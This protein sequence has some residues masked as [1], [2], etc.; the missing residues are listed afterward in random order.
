MGDHVDPQLGNYRLLHLIGKGSFAH[1]YLGEHTHLHT[2]VA[3]K[4]LQFKLDENSTSD[5]LDK[6]STIAHLVHP[7]IL[8]VL[9]FGVQDTIPFLVMDYVPRGTLGQ[10]F[11]RGKPLPP[12]PLAPYMKQAAAAL[13]HGHDRNLL[14]RSVKPENMLL[15]PNDEIL[16]ADFG[17]T[18]IT[19]NVVPRFPAE[20]T[21]NAAY[22]APEQLQGRPCPASD[23]YALAVVAYEWLTGSRP[24]HGSLLEIARQQINRTAPVLRERV[25]HIPANIEAVVMKALN[26]DPQQRYPNVKDFSLALED[27]CLSS[28]QYAFSS[29]NP[30][31][32]QPPFP[33][34]NASRPLSLNGLTPTNAS[35]PL[36]LNGLPPT[37]AS[38]P[39]SLNGLTPIRSSGVHAIND[40]PPLK[41]TPV[42]PSSMAGIS[43]ANKTSQHN[44]NNS[45]KTGKQKEK[46]VSVRQRPTSA[47][48]P[49]TSRKRPLKL[50]SLIIISTVILIIF[51]KANGIS[52]LANIWQSATN[53]SMQNSGQNKQLNPIPASTKMPT[54]VQEK[55][56]Y[57][58][59]GTLVLNN[60]LTD[61]NGSWQQGTMIAN[62]GTCALTNSTGY[63]VTAP[64]I[65]P[66]ECIEQQHTYTNFTYEVTM[67]FAAIKQLYSGGGITFRS[68]SDDRQYYYFELFRNGLY[69]LQI[70]NA[71]DCTRTLDGYKFNKPAIPAFDAGVGATNVL[72]VVANNNAFA[73]FVN[74]QLVVNVTDNTY[75]QGH[76]GVMA[77][78]GNDQGLRTTATSTPTTAIFSNVKVW[79]LNQ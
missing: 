78:G 55:N 11:L 56:P 60:P 17:L 69:T 13:Q 25:P 26:K 61:S 75:T 37:N 30:R 23:Q 4:V 5:F 64:I 79:T 3:V 20:T 40:R 44:N 48:A 21:E 46:H 35:R 18:M 43:L 58:T 6:V 19:Q 28:R 10:R 24:F 74:R 31:N 16:L 54:P 59:N 32:S 70:C 22:M 41:T 73:I 72:A 47:A 7:C 57:A 9:D 49:F 15:C 68:S 36:S 14:H 76:I 53:T 45:A 2:Q 27:A 77:T 71:G 39:L 8:R 12:G 29:S 42:N 1:V 66:G 65:D 50:F 34:T 51:A 62:G 52:M 63:V 38:R 67:K 33:P